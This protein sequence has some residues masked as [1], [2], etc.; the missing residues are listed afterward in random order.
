[1][2]KERAFLE[3]ESKGKGGAARVKKE[4]HLGWHHC[5]FPGYDMG[6]CYYLV[7]ASRLSLYS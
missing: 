2:R 5:Q 1:M 3:K 4:M 7:T 6:R